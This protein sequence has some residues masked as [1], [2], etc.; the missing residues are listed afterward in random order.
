M[1]LRPP[2]CPG[3]N[4]R[5]LLRVVAV[6]SVVKYRD[7]LNSSCPVVVRQCRRERIIVICL[8]AEERLVAMVHVREEME[9][10]WTSIGCVPTVGA[11]RAPLTH[12]I[13]S[14]AC[15]NVSSSMS[16]LVVL[17]L[18]RKE[19]LHDTRMTSAMAVMICGFQEPDSNNGAAQYRNNTCSKGYASTVRSRNRWLRRFNGREEALRHQEKKLPQTAASWQSNGEASICAAVLVP[20]CGQE[21]AIHIADLKARQT[22]TRLRPNEA[23]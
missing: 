9:W 3:S 10:D 15:L 22:L 1:H 17:E 13:R 14:R 4:S 23:A 20:P 7:P 21:Q 11:S 16:H 6:P 18:L 5:I 2:S 8:P 12:E 19:N